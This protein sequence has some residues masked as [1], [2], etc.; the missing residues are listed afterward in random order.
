MLILLYKY[1]CLYCC[2]NMA[3]NLQYHAMIIVFKLTIFNYYFVSLNNILK[4][5]QNRLTYT[6]SIIT[7]Q[8]HCFQ[9]RTTL[10]GKD[11]KFL[12]SWDMHR[13]AEHPS[14]THARKKFWILINKYGPGASFSC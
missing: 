7:S 9:V 12:F 14:S 1:V 10:N 13:E 2:I 8:L 3:S 5:V 6:L 4:F 11:F